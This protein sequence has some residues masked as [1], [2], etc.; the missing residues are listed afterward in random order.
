MELTKR[1][2]EMG[3]GK[4][5]PL[6]FKFGIPTMLGMV[7]AELP[8]AEAISRAVIEATLVR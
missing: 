1:E 5:I 8:D 6:L 2:I 3:T 4:T 7:A